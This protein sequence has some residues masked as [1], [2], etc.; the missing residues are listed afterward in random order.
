MKRFRIAVL[1]P[2]LALIFVSFSV[3]A[4]ADT[5]S[6]ATVGTT[7]DYTSSITLNSVT[8]PAHTSYVSDEYFGVIHVSVRDE[9]VVAATM[10]TQGHV[11]MTAVGPGTTTVYFWFK[12]LATDSWTLAR[13][14]ITVSDT[15]TKVTTTAYTGLVFSE[16]SASMAQNSEY[17]AT[18]IMVNGLPVE[19]T[20]LLWVASPSSVITVDAGTGKV[21][22]VGTGTAV[23]YAIDPKTNSTSSISIT[24]Y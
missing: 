18:G 17:T 19:A 9:N 20:S 11:V 12:T 10:D 6:T 4:F 24:V 8:L 22:A 3:A 21:T 1:I 23:L 13:V 7:D 5:D 15:A 2:I 14:P 16:T